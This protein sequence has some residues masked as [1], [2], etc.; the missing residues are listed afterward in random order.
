MRTS[1]HLNVGRSLPDTAW[2]AACGEWV[3]LATHAAMGFAFRSMPGFQGMGA[4]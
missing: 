2:I 1:E 3:R 4:A